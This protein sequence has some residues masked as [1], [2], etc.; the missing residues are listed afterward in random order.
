MINEVKAEGF[1]YENVG[2]TMM[3]EHN[4][5]CV[6]LFLEVHRE[7]E[8]THIMSSF[9]LVPL[10]IHDISMR[11]SLSMFIMISSDHFVHL[12]AYV[13]LEF[14]LNLRK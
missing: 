3:D 9:K 1:E 4:P 12:E 5:G 6:Q 10:S 2:T 13:V 11:N 14:K 7:I 8:S